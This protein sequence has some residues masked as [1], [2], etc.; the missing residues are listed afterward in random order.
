MRPRC[1]GDDAATWA[2]T[3]PL[4]PGLAH[5]KGACANSV[6]AVLRTGRDVEA[7]AAFE[8]P[9]IDRVVTGREVAGDFEFLTIG[10]DVSRFP[11]SEGVA[12]AYGC[13]IPVESHPVTVDVNEHVVALGSLS[14]E[15]PVPR[16]HEPLA[17]A[18][19]VI[20]GEPEVEAEE[21]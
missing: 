13:V 6:L 15:L 10:D 9:D 11:E 14:D 18:H 1:L 7:F 21:P 20:F 3:R 17:W 16:D 4:S 19:R 5:A 12:S 2:R 8:H